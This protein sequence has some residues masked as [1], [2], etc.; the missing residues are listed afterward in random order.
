MY[1]S[2]Q[3]K[4][5]NYASYD[6]TT[7]KSMTYRHTKNWLR[8]RI[9]LKTYTKQKKNKQAYNINNIGDI[10]KFMPSSIFQHRILSAVWSFV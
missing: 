9:F 7:T 10:P 2:K 8:G 4:I 6:V 1:G 3:Q 5:E